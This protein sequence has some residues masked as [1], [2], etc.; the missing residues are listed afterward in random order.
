MANLVYA[1]YMGLAII[2]GT[3]IRCSDM[4][5][6]NAQNVHYYDHTIGLRDSIVTGSAVKGDVGNLNYQ[7]YI[8]SPENE[9]A[10]GTIS[11]PVTEKS[12]LQK[13]FDLIKTGDSFSC[14]IDNDCQIGQNFEK[15]RA[16]TFTLSLQA[17]QPATVSFGV[18]GIFK[19]ESTG[20]SNYNTAEKIITWDKMNISTALT[21]TDSIESFD[22]SANNECIPIYTNNAT[23]KP[24]AIRVGKQT[25]SGNLKYYVKGRS[26][27][28]LT[29]STSSQPITLTIGDSFTETITVIYQPIQRPGSP[30][31]I[32]HTIPFV[33]Y[34]KALGV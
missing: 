21:T 27:Q 7:K 6:S 25:V 14:T 31:T 12:G 19:D 34:G 5:I 8:W 28:S 29:Y 23:L 2:D 22:L 32:I 18:M 24:Y 26:H 20:A 9:I 33:G 4:S 17:G 10:Q 3:K 16:E 11:F 13:C 1:G 30:S 15:C